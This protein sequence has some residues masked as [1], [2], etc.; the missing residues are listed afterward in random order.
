MLKNLLSFDVT[1]A[2]LDHKQRR[3]FSE[4]FMR[5][6]NHRV[7]DNA[8]DDADDFLDLGRRNVLSTADDQFLEPSSD[9]QEAVFV[10][11]GEIAGMIPAVAQRCGGFLWLVMI[12]DHHIRTTNDELA[13]AAEPARHQRAEVQQGIQRSQEEGRGNNP[14]GTHGG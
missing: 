11:P 9:G 12:S 3:N 6:S 14:G 2:T 1:I 5:K 10:A 4:M 8:V 7:I 13:L